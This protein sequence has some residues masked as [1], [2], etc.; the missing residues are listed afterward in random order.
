MAKIIQSG[1]FLG[2]TLSNLGKKVLS[3]LVAPLAKDVLLKL[4]AKPTLSVLNKLERKINGKGAVIIESLEKSDLLI[5]GAT[6]TV[7]HKIEKQEDEF[8]GRYYGTYGCFI[9]ST[10][11]FFID[12]TCGFII[13]KCFIWKR[14][15]R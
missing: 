13:D 11:G 7:K 3:D 1:G 10:Y 14:T 4:A 9:D 6:K 8:P 12:T 15:R 5:D 2:K